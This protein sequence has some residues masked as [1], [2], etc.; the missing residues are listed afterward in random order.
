MLTDNPPNIKTLHEDF[1][2]ELIV[3]FSGLLDSFDYKGDIQFLEL[4]IFNFRQKKNMIIEF[5]GLYVGLWSMALFH[6]FPN[7]HDAIL[8]RFIEKE[9]PKKYNKKLLP[10]QVKRIQQYS[11]LIRG[12]SNIDFNPVSHHILSLLHVKES[13]FRTINLKIALHIRSVYTYIFE[14]LF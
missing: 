10:L 11:E 14:R 8:Q 4:G 1:H 12:N 3:N 6:S 5:Q 2:E 13:K 7:D 9:L